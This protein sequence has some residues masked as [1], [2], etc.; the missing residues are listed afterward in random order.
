[1]VHWDQ[2][3]LVGRI[4]RPHGLRGQVAVNPETDFP[5]ERF[6]PGAT[7]WTQRAGPPEALTIASMR[8]QNGRPVIAFEGWSRLED[9]AGLAGL[10]L[11]VPEEALQPLEPGRYYEHDLIGCAVD[12]LAGARL[13]PVVR[14][15]RGPGGSRLVVSAAHGET[16]IPLAV[17]ICVDVDVVGKRIRIDPPDGLI[18]LNVVG[19][20]R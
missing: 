19:S 5:A 9:V 10:E 17:E 11:R 6:R 12:T 3:V 4:A 18:E 14:V 16:L 1:M 7:V 2:M 13:G 15:E 8:V 20:R